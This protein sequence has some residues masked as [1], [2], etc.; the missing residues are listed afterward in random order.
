MSAKWP[1]SIGDRRGLCAK[2][3]RV[4]WVRLVTLEELAMLVLAGEVEYTNFQPRHSWPY[5]GNHYLCAG[6][7]CPTRREKGGELN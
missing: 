3:K 5:V 7:D 4:M 1:Y 6:K 2:H